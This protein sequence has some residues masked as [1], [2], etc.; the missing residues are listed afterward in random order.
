T[1]MVSVELVAGNYFDVLGVQP[2]IGRLL[3]QDDDKVKNGNPVVVLQYNY[4]MSRFGGKKDIVGSSIRLNGTPFTVIGVA[5]TGFDGVDSGLP[6]NVWVPIMMKPTITPT[7][8]D[9]DNERNAWFYL[10]ARLKPGVTSDQAQAALRVL[11]RQ[12]QEEELHGELF[13]KFP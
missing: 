4:W 1:E 7:W 11:N 12:R 13:Q 3:S 5:A 8:D 2:Y 6:S 9:L 10:F